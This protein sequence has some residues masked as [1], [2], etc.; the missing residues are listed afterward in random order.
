[1]AFPTRVLF[2]VWKVRN[3]QF[4]AHDQVNVSFVGLTST[5]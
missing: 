3:S 1:M 4:D 2:E 5:A